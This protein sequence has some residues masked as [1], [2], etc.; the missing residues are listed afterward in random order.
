MEGINQTELKIDL[1]FIGHFERFKNSL[2]YAFVVN[3]VSMTLL[4]LIHFLF[5]KPLL[6]IMV[7][8]AGGGM[9]VFSLISYFRNRN[10]SKIYIIKAYLISEECLSITVYDKNK[11]IFA[12][13][14]FSVNDISIDR[15]L[16]VDGRSISYK[17]VFTYRKTNHV[18]FEQYPYGEW[19]KNNLIDSFYD[20]I[21]EL[22]PAF[23]D[24]THK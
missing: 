11:L 4:I 20:T 6:F 18:M 5:L 2:K 1:P 8:V 22:A 14:P 15:V 12:D 24:K 23:I 7:P 17:I 13:E 3:I 9:I 19:A 10:W 21:K 16:V